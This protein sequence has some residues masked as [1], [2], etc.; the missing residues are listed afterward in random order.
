MDLAK[1]HV[2]EGWQNMGACDTIDGECDLNEIWD[3]ITAEILDHKII[4]KAKLGEI[5]KLVSSGGFDLKGLSNNKKFSA[6]T[7][8]GALQ[9]VIRPYKLDVIIDDPSKVSEVLD[10][11]LGVLE[12]YS[13]TD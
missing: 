3:I 2:I 6:N 8:E 12:D 11:V 1:E 9:D 10:K 4:N 7:L 5:L 13:L